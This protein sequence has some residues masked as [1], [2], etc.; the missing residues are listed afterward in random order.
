M[1]VVTFKAVSTSE[2][3]ATPYIFNLKFLV[4]KRE[5]QLDFMIGFITF[6]RRQTA[7]VDL[8]GRRNSSAA[9]DFL[10]VMYF[11]VGRLDCSCAHLPV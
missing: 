9:T 10:F 7:L 5:F 1:L 11:L 2:H 4:K 6:W 3:A 8:K